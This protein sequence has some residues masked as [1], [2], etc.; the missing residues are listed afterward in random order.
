MILVM[1]GGFRFACSSAF[2]PVENMVIDPDNI[3]SVTLGLGERILSGEIPELF[4]SNGYIIFKIEGKDDLILL[5]DPETGIVRDVSTICGAYCFHDQITDNLIQK[6]E[7]INSNDQNERPE[8]LNSISEI[9]IASSASV[10]VGLNAVE[11]A[12]ITIGGVEL[13]AVCPPVLVVAGGVL[14]ATTIFN[15]CVNQGWLP[16]ET[17]REILGNV[18]PLTFGTINLFIYGEPPTTL[19]QL[20][21]ACLKAGYLLTSITESEYEEIYHIAQNDPKVLEERISEYLGRKET[22]YTPPIIPDGDE[23]E[24]LLNLYNVSK[25]L[26]KSGIED[27]N[28]GNY[29]IGTAKVTLGTGGV[30]FWGSYLIIELLPEG[31]LPKIN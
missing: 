30:Y 7:D 4:M 19:K 2:S 12:G 17:C 20:K 6:A 31:V 18:F 10:L 26:I 9:S 24:F 16:P 23:G 8:W 22:S 13:A 21:E 29:V 15:Y 5:L 11:A 1:C 27:Y 14:V 3:G 28:A 25:E